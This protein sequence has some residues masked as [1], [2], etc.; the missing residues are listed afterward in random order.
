MPVILNT[1]EADIEGSQNQAHLGNMARL[2]SKNNNN[3]NN[4]YLKIAIRLTYVITTK[5]TII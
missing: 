3:N 4:M 2:C 5:K 1:Q